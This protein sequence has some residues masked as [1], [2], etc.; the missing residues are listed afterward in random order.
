VSDVVRNR[1]TD[2]LFNVVE[3]AINGGI[4]A[5]DFRL[6]LLECWNNALENKIKYD[7]KTLT[8]TL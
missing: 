1:V 5:K 2:E 7:R 6:I 4:S 8:E 3:S